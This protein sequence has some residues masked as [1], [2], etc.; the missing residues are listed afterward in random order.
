MPC[1]TLDLDNSNDRY[2]NNPLR[3]GAHSLI[4]KRHR[5]ERLQ[6]NVI[7]AAI[8]LCSRCY[9]NREEQLTTA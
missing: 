8:V 6:N 3:Q 9:R 5:N 1:I 4:G 2:E 7:S